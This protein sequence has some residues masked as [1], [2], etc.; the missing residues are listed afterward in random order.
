M[1]NTFGI[2]TKKL[3]RK[4]LPVFAPEAKPEKFLISQL[5]YLEICRTKGG[6]GESPPSI[7]VDR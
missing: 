3:S 1:E 5:L 4:S 2:G 7:Y 6:P